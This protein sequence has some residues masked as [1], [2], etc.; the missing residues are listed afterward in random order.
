MKAYL[1]DLDARHASEVGNLRSELAEALNKLRAAES[2]LNAIRATDLRKSDGRCGF[3]G[4][5]PDRDCTP[6]CLTWKIEK[7]K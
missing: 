4:T 6:N 2:L 5:E 7:Y 3:C 1:D